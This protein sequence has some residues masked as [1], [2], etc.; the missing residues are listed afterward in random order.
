MV[1]KFKSLNFSKFS[2][3]ISLI[4]LFSCS[5]E[6]ITNKSSNQGKSYQMKG[7]FLEPTLNNGKLVFNTSNDFENFISS[8]IDEDLEEVYNVMEPF[9]ENGFY[10]LRPPAVEGHNEEAIIL[11]Y[12]ERVLNFKQKYNVNNY[13]N[14]EIYE[15]IDET[16]D[17]ILLDLFAAIIN[18][19]G[20]LQIADNLSL[21]HI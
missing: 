5:Q 11:Q 6:E 20:E 17:I 7:S 13:T 2:F 18:S 16:T 10:S 19:E 3:L 21:I 8:F 4:F 1:Q 12:Q 9:Y 15:K 14:E